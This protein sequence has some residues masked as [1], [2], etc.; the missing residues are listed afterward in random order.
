MILRFGSS[1]RHSTAAERLRT[2]LP[3]R[4]AHVWL[5]ALTLATLV[6]PVAAEP[7]PSEACEALDRE[8]DLLEGGGAGANIA[9]GAEWG[10]GNLTPEQVSY[11]RRLIEVREQIEFRCRTFAVVR[12][13]APPA[14]PPT[15][16]DAV[17]S[18]DRRPPQTSDAVTAA[19]KPA[20]AK[21][22]IGVPI[23]T[24][25]TPEPATAKPKKPAVRK[26]RVE[27]AT[28]PPRPNDAY[29]PPPGTES[30]FQV[31]TDAL[32][33]EPTPPR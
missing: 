30:T 5:A 8:R 26:P 19:G 10:K 20:V 13:P 9:R 17:P 12:E 2:R 18:P 14:P 6:L 24:R 23:P 27:A 22:A 29:V 32:R 31:P 28:P 11:V 1:S 7:L 3:V 33:M 21:A 16:P 25:A 15:A 4:L